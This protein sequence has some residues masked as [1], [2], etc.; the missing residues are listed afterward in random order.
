MP[1]VPEHIVADRRRKLEQLV[2]KERY[3]PVGIVAEKLGISQAT[4]R[5]DLAAL[6]EQQRITRTFGGVVATGATPASVDGLD[7]FANHAQRNDHMAT[8]KRKIA[9]AVAARIKPG[10][11]LFMD[12]GTTV[13]ALA[14][15]LS[16]IPA[17]QLKNVRIITHSLP[18]AE[19]LARI[20]TIE[21]HLPGG[22]L[23]TGQLVLLGEATRRALMAFD[24]DLA[25][26]G[27][28]AVNAEG[29]FNSHAQSVEIQ[30]HIALRAARTVVM[31]D[32][33]KLGGEAG[34]RLLMPAEIDLIA[35][36]APLSKVGAAG[37]DV[38]AR[39]LL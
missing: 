5:R 24:I 38:T 14:M 11:T 31:F 23:I 28:E 30:R 35:T 9:K 26:F 3:L 27:A 12:A 4:A 25:I 8:A 7:G 39:Q 19:A 15:Y 16:E 2:G 22:R 34:E 6:Q 37:I 13:G 20:D 1:R 36:D 33:S 29:V 32:S 17:K 18:I 10:M 21:T